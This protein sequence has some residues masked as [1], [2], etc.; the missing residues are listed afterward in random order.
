M[1]KT[2]SLHF[3]MLATLALTFVELLNALFTHDLNATPQQTLI[4]TLFKP[5]YLQL[6][7]QLLLLVFMALICAGV[8]KHIWNYFIAEIAKVRD[9]N[10]NEAYALSFI[11]VWCTAG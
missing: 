5:L 2:I 6:T 4:S 9:I 11:F 8:F 10:L 3:N 1:K 7:V